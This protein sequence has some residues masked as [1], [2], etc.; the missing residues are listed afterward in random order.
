METLPE[1][2]FPCPCFFYHAKDDRKFWQEGICMG[3]FQE[4][5]AMN[6]I[7]NLNILWLVID[8]NG[9][10]HKIYKIKDVKFDF[11]ANA[12]T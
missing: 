3:V 4:G 6:S 1:I 7:K 11:P 12:T 10:P 9:E 2:S 5:T 8:K